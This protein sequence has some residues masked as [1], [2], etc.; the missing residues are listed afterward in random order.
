MN[1]SATYGSTHTAGEIGARVSIYF[2]FFVVKY[3]AYLE[4]YSLGILMQGL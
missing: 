1:Y 4:G 3:S 2:W